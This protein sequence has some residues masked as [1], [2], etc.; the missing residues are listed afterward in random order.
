MPDDDFDL[1][2]FR[3]AD[4]S[5]SVVPKTAQPNR[6]SRGTGPVKPFIVA[7]PLGWESKAARLPGKV[8]HV[9]RALRYLSGLAKTT[10]GIK[11]QSRV[12]S[13]FGVSHQSYNRGLKQLETAGLVTVERRQGQRPTVS[14]LDE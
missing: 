5:P 10:S 8:L 9:A 7:T 13:L 11:M 2:D 4:G 1:S 12:L 14:I 6:R 3:F